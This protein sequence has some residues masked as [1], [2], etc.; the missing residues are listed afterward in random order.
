MSHRSSEFTARNTLPEADPEKIRSDE[1][2]YT[3][4]L[5]RISFTQPK[6]ADLLIEY[7]N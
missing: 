6:L 4:V 3:L 1:N 2:K 5:V 7:R